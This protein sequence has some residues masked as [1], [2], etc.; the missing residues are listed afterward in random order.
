MT[1]APDSLAEVP[2]ETVLN[3][4]W[5]SDLAIVR[6]CRPQ[7]QTKQHEQHGRGIGNERSSSSLKSMLFAALGRC[8]R[9]TQAAS[10]PHAV[11]GQ[12]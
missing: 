9:G 2:S 11:G 1:V 4:V 10:S 7:P 12:V 3:L 8:M 5:H 6:C